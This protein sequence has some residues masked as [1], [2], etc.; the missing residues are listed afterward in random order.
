M[1]Y[2]I[3]KGIPFNEVRSHRYPVAQMEIGDSFLVTDPDE[4]RRASAS[5][6]RYGV[7]TG[8]VFRSRKTQEGVRIWRVA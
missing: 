8:K 5:S 4:F 1:K 7:R 2:E 6:N 3:Q